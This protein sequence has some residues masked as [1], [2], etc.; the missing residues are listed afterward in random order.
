M[1]VFSD[2]LDLDNSEN[3]FQVKVGFSS[4]HW[5]CLITAQKRLMEIERFN[6]SKIKYQHDYGKRVFMVGSANCCYSYKKLLRR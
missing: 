5:V 1:I 4:F 2:I 3:N 6:L